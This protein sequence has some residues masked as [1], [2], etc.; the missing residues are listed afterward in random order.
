L[1]VRVTIPR[2]PGG[3]FDERRNTSRVFRP[4]PRALDDALEALAAWRAR[5]PA[6][7][8]WI[9]AGAPT[10]ETQFSHAMLFGTPHAGRR[11]K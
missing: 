9:E 3:T 10:I 8:A 7:A 1:G 11:R 2:Q 6:H 5:E 4:G